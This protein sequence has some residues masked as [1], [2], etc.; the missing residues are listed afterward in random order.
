MS[1]MTVC[2]QVKLNGAAALSFYRVRLPCW[3]I[4]GASRS[5]LWAPDTVY[6]N[7]EYD[8]LHIKQDEMYLV[9]FV[10]KLK[11]DYDPHHVGLRNLALCSNQLSGGAGKGLYSIEPSTI[12]PESMQV[13][14]DVLSGLHQMWFVS[15]QIISRVLAGCAPGR[16][17]MITPFF[18]RSFPI[19]AMPLHFDRVGA[20]PRSIGK[21]LSNLHILRPRYLYHTW[22]KILD[23]LDIKLPNTQYRFLLA[24]N[25][26]RANDDLYNYD[27]AVRWLKKEDDIWMGSH[28]KIS[29]PSLPGDRPAPELPEFRD[30]DLNAAMRPAVG[31]WLFPVDA[32]YDGTEQTECDNAWSKWDVKDHWP[33]L[34]LLRMVQQPRAADIVPAKR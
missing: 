11:V 18:E 27:D 13:L 10:H 9:D 28:R 5:D 20:D 25:P 32:F 31:F 3:L 12:S 33:E 2:Y 17:S 23:K 30:E 14:K 7:P 4:E 6:Y 19:I 8:F 21:D 22:Q 1:S 15:I 34:A 24:F 16:P 26:I 29:A